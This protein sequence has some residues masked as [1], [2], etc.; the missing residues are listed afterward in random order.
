MNPTFLW[1]F[2]AGSGI[3]NAKQE[4]PGDMV[5][6]DSVTFKL[7]VTCIDGYEDPGPIPDTLIITVT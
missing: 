5:F 7:S 1:D 3:A 2:G 4:D 6:D